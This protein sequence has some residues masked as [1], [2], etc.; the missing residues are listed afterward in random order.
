MRGRIDAATLLERAIVGQAAAA[1]APITVSAATAT[2]WAS[3]T[4]VGA[5]HRLTIDGPHGAA[6][7]A[8]LAGLAE[9]DLPIRGH[10]VADLVV[11]GSAHADGRFT[12]TVEVLTLREG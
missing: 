2:R 3:A 4:F 8:W 1:G 6:T 10:L 12:A 11:L 9:A 7:D 5:R